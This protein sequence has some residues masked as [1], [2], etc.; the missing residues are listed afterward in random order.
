MQGPGPSLSSPT[1]VG[2]NRGPILCF[3]GTV[4]LKSTKQAPPG[5]M[6]GQLVTS[7]GVAVPLMQSTPTTFGTH[8]LSS[9]DRMRATVCGTL[10]FQEGRLAV[11]V[12]YVSPG[13]S[14]T[15]PGVS[16]LALIALSLLGLLPVA[17]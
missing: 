4:N 6:L 13:T 9:V 16:P 11:D 3:V 17:N 5:S 12:C 7:I 8:S 1:I 14:T 15:T 2:E 10:L